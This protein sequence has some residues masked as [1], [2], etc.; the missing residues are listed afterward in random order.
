MSRDE[1]SASLGEASDRW[2][3]TMSADP[4]ISP[5][6]VVV[7]SLMG[8]WVSIGERNHIV[9]SNVG[10]YTYTGDGATINYA[11]I[12]KFTS[13]AANVCIGPVNHPTDRVTQHH[14]TYRRRAYGFADADDGRIFAWRRQQRVTIDHDVW[15]GHGAIVL[16]GI[17]I[18]T[19]AVVGAGAVV[20]K[21]VPAYTIVAGV[22]A[23]KLRDRFPPGIAQSL[24]KTAWWDWSREQLTARFADFDNLYEFLVKYG[25]Q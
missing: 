4:C 17:H 24:L 13:I 7:E 20:T 25:Q 22:P 23:A 1:T 3:E 6:A 19:G 9:E 18:G 11:E 16:A 2:R 10:D 21:D 12:G 15:I 8:R 5:T 14:A